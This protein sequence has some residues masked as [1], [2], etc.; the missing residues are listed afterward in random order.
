MLEHTK[1]ELELNQSKKPLDKSNPFTT[2]T[3]EIAT[4]S[5]LRE[6]I[7]STPKTPKLDFLNRSEI[8]ITSY[9]VSK[10]FSTPTKSCMSS[11]LLTPGSMKNH[12]SSLT[13]SRSNLLETPQK[14][15]SEMSHNLIELNS[16]PVYGHKKSMHLIDL[17][18]PFLKS[19]KQFNPRHVTSTPKT[20]EKN[21]V[22][23][24]KDN[25]LLKSAIK[26]S[27]VKKRWAVNGR[28]ITLPS[29]TTKSDVRVNSSPI[30]N[31]PLYTS[32]CDSSSVI[33]VNGTLDD[34]FETIPPS[35]NIESNED[36]ESI[37]IVLS[38]QNTNDAA[39]SPGT[40][41][42]LK[43]PQKF[44]KNDT[45]DVSGVRE[46]IKT[47]TTQSPIVLKMITKTPKILNEIM[48][49]STNVSIIKA[50]HSDSD[51]DGVRELLSSISSVLDD[52]NNIM[53]NETTSAVGE[54]FPSN[55][56]K[57]IEEL[58]TENTESVVSETVVASIDNGPNNIIEPEFKTMDRTFDEL[59]GIP[60][61]TKT[62]NRKSSLCVLDK[63]NEDSANEMKLKEKECGERVIKWIEDVKAS[64][65]LE[66]SN[67]SR[68]Q[69]IS[70]RYSNVTPNDSLVDSTS[71][72]KT[73]N[74]TERSIDGNGSP[75]LSIL[76]TMEH[77]KQ[78]NFEN[79]QINQKL[80]MSPV[81]RLSIMDN[82]TEVL[83]NYQIPNSLRSTRKKFGMAIASLLNV[84]AQAAEDQNESINNSMHSYNNESKEAEESKSS[85]PNILSLDDYQQNDAFCG[86]ENQAPLYQSYIEFVKTDD[87]DHGSDN[88]VFE[89]S[90][91]N[92]SID[93]SIESDLSSE[94]ECDN[95]SSSEFDEF[96]VESGTNDKTSDDLFD[97][98]KP[99][100]NSSDDDE[101]E[102]GASCNLSRI[103]EQ[104]FENSKFILDNE[105]QCKLYFSLFL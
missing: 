95:D 94:N 29:S 75:R 63:M 99:I 49:T 9:S 80:T 26:N 60:T 28:S 103:D 68:V 77:L 84:S 43:T 55:S 92:Q 52:S 4:S 35:I 16:T 6:N 82:S 14:V 32:C 93:E 76:E 70:A 65:S 66:S 54:E 58:A 72:D 98:I 41:N 71:L 5:P 90:D 85:S 62:Y 21:T 33:E 105:N 96:I 48:V 18:T 78:V 67:K 17:T 91:S 22:S 79:S 19:P 104:R 10:S 50:E 1:H 20:T 81:S 25:T 59:I 13:P 37:S 44:Q 101:I 97:D 23:T 57:I 100:E 36:T 56:V 7:S 64:G 74:V 53:K 102:A 24:R 31:S 39:N 47:P 38:S 42:M 88:E 15:L 61:I 2:P 3:R 83:E 30:A 51:E 8:L 73:S 27:T 89:I 40:S 34:T 12:N 86:K 69:I 11:K 45:R 46:L 87:C